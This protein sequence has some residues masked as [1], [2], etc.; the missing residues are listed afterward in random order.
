MSVNNF[1][2]DLSRLE[3]I[4]TLLE[5]GKCTLAEAMTLFEEGIG[6]SKECNKSLEEAKSKLTVLSAENGEN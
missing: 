2:K 5:S 4:V 6:L 3:E 1:E